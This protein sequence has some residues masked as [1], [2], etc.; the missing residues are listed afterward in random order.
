MKKYSFILFAA[1]AL[2]LAACDKENSNIEQP[3]KCPAE[4]IEVLNPV[5]EPEKIVFSVNMDLGQS[6]V[7]SQ[8]ATKASLS[9]LDITWAGSEKIFIANDVNDDIEICT[10]TK[11]PTYPTK[12]TISV[13]SVGGAET[14]YAYYN[15]ETTTTDISFD[16]TTA[17]FSGDK[18]ICRFNEFTKSKPHRT[19][20]AMAGKTT[21][22]NLVL[23]PCLS[24]VKFQIHA[25]S[26][27]GEYV[28]EDDA[29]YTCVRGFNLLLKHSGSRTKCSGTYTVDLSGVSMVVSPTDD[30]KSFDHKQ[31]S[32][33]TTLESSTDY[34]FSVIPVGS[35]EKIELGFL[36]WVW[37]GAQYVTAW[38]S[39]YTMSLEQ[40]LSIDSG[41]YFNFGTLNPVGLQKAYDSFVPAISIDGTMT[42]WSGKDM[43]PLDGEKEAFPGDGANIIE[44]KATSDARNIYFYF[45]VTESVVEEKGQWDARI[46]IA[47]DTDNNG[48]SGGDAS[49]NLGSGF[50]ALI[51]AK[52]FSN[53]ASSP[54]TFTSSPAGEIKYPVSGSSVGTVETGGRSDG[55]GYVYAEICVPRNK[56]GSPASSAIIRVQPSLEWASTCSA[57]TITLE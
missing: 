28:D 2:C 20:L 33:A 49:Y 10:L 57:Q 37:D 8:V 22:D 30:S 18:V 45:K 32:S 31:I 44:W 29:D 15:S 16:H 51:K 50:E 36:G 41:D 48:S 55:A 14:Y 17:T 53:D 4:E 19:D 3:E 9:T 5:Q 13:T 35:I 52:P 54:V 23:K 43:Y 27:N 25:N 11:D 24:L 42:D 46:M 1:L 6:N 26:V 40:S 12:G 21:G 39:A 7:S 34:Y 38:D 47:L 56:I